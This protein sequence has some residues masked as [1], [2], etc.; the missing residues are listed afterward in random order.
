MS[1]YCWWCYYVVMY[2][3]WGELLSI[4]VLDTTKK[5][6][7]SNQRPAED[8]GKPARP[9]NKNGHTAS[10]I[11]L[12]LYIFKFLMTDWMSRRLF[13]ISED[14]NFIDRLTCTKNT[15]YLTL[16]FAGNIRAFKNYST[17]EAW[18]E[19]GTVIVF[20][21]LHCYNIRRRRTRPFNASNVFAD[22]PVPAS[23]PA[24][25][26]LVHIVSTRPRTLTLTLLQ[27]C[28]RVVLLIRRMR[29]PEKNNAKYSGALMHNFSTLSVYHHPCSW[30][31]YHLSGSCCKT[32]MERKGLD[33]PENELRIKISRP[34]QR[35]DFS[36]RPKKFTLLTHLTFS[37]L[38]SL[39]I[40]PFDVHS[41]EAISSTTGK[42]IPTHS[43]GSR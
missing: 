13:S 26:R 16:T 29:D 36:A 43:L 32:K 35:R 37:V 27:I 10:S 23:P 22:K 39:W 15:F 25:L 3:L 33:D 8:D 40:E 11:L 41:I 14:A 6:S 38:P 19:V 21:I 20:F 31:A 4:A 24:R 12:A 5:S 30:E 1:P 2:T 18:Y 28:M 7:E 9:P 42:H 17:Y 34:K